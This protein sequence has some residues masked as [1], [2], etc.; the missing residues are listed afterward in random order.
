MTGQ[1]VNGGLWTLIGLVVTVVASMIATPFTIRLFG[2]EAYGVWA[3]LQVA[4][5]YMSVADL[6]MGMAS[7]RFGSEAFA[8]RDEKG[9]IAIV[10]TSLLICAGPLLLLSLI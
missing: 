5:S 10:W 6:G 3:I 7:T 4:I 8:R 1:I 9:E 2:S